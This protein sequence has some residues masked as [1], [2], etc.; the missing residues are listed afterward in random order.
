MNHEIEWEHLTILEEIGYGSSASVYR[1]LLDGEAY[2]VKRVCIPS[3]PEE[4]K[5][6]IRALGSEDAAKAY[7]MERAQACQH[8][9]RMLRLL[10][11]NPHIA[12]ILATRITQNEIGCEVDFLMES[13]EPFTEYMT[14]HVLHEENVIQLAIDLCQGL[15]ALENAR[16]IHR[17]L[18]P[19]NILVD[20]RQDKPVFKLCDFGE[21]KILDHT[22]LSASVAGTF[23]Y[24]A[25]EVYHGK[26][27]DNRAD[28]YALGM[29]LYRLMNHGREPFV[30]V[31]QRIVSPTQKEDAFIRRMKGEA[32]PSPEQASAGLSDIILRACAYYP[33]K[34]YKSAGELQDELASLIAHPKRR[35]KHGR[36]YGKRTGR[37]YAA[38]GVISLLL[39]LLS[40]VSLHW[41]REYYV[42]L[43][44]PAI[45][46]HLKEYG[47]TSTARL[48]GNGVL[49]IESMDDLYCAREDGLYPWSMAKDRVRKIVFGEHVDGTP[50]LLT[51]ST[52]MYAPLGTTD[53]MVYRSV[54]DSAVYISPGAFQNFPHLREIEILSHTFKFSPAIP[55][56]YCPNLTTITVPEDADILLENAYSISETPW[57]QEKGWRILGTTLVRYNG[58]DTALDRFPASIFRIAPNA[59]AENTALVSLSLPEGI[60]DIGS[61]AF[62][63]C[64]SLFSLTLPDSLR[65]IGS[66]A[67]MDCSALQS[68]MLPRQIEEIG[69]NAF[70]GCS[71][72]TSLTCLSP[73]YLVENGV[74]YD[75][76]QVDLLWCSPAVSGTLVVP[77]ST[78]RI[79]INAFQD[80]WQLAGLTITSE[81]T[82]FSS[83]LFGACP[84]LTQLT[85]SAYDTSHT[86][87]DGMLCTTSKSIPQLMFV[88]RDTKG[89]IEVPDG[90]VTLS[91]YAFA[92]CRDVTE[93]ILPPSL[94]YIMDYAFS[95]CTGLTSLALPGNLHFI[96]NHV[97]S[98]CTQLC[99]V[100]FEGSRETW[101]QLTDRFDIGLS[102]DVTLHFGS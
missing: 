34:R 11:E 26:K 24:M 3:T 46:A 15:I 37:F 66:G 87:S 91:G 84:L 12:S 65:T 61:G 68:L 43:C 93:I 71:Q 55:I 73:S 22:L 2:A 16:I 63:G 78:E 45:V 85:L 30:P 58:E 41:Y 94:S 88:L 69:E 101:E 62:S 29:I 100:Y 48:N 83:S 75:A 23:G 92:S 74:L 28:I 47:I 1:A 18:K 52:V 53:N 9:A 19:E 4:E 36:S 8:E 70:R 96:S 72:L 57:Y 31:S 60:V 59:F 77:E 95:G 54:T 6:L 50:T 99:D 89:R 44:D 51:P 39:V 42:N 79:H 67:F 13:L 32:L 21:A 81:D 56:A 14:L 38:V 7:C 5:D 82:A 33:E 35:G 98:G 80:A 17:D 76:S 10:P 64:T 90:T 49:Y 20:T 86:L 40:F 27:Y 102:D 97:F 25:P